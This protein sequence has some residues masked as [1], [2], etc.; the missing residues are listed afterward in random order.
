MPLSTYCAR[1][2]PVRRTP[3]QPERAAGSG[4]RSASFGQGLLK[5]QLSIALVVRR[6]RGLKELA[7][8]RHGRAS[9]EQPSALPLGQP[10]PNAMLD[11]AVEGVG[12]ALGAHSA[13]VA[14]G[15]GPVL[16]SPFDEQFVGVGRAAGRSLFPFLTRGHC[17]AVPPRVPPAARSGSLRQIREA[18]AAASIPGE[19]IRRR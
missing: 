19:G 10:A 18:T 11:T 9:A 3:S 12:E 4:R 15:L 8:R 14:N 2:G 5:T 7:P 13:S 16:R 1:F 17:G 6:T